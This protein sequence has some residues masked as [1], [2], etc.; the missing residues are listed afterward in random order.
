MSTP[1]RVNLYDSQTSEYHQAFQAFLDHTDQKLKAQDWLNRLVTSLP[2]RR[3]FI[4]V[5]AGNGKVTSWFI[6]SFEQTIATEPNESLRTEL[7]KNCPQIE[8]LPDRILNAKIADTGDFVLCSHVLY[9][10]DSAEWLFNLERL[11][12]WLSLDGVLV[13]VLQHHMSDCMQMLQHFFDRRFD[14]TALART[15]QAENG[16]W[17]E[18]AI[19]TVSAHVTTLNFN[20]AYT[21]AEFMLN[22]LPMSNPPTR[23]DLEEYVRKYFT[24]QDGGFRFSCDQDFLQIRPRKLPA[25]ATPLLFRDLKGPG[26]N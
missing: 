20:S 10:I 1:Q 23:S 18:V 14:L 16:D 13:V 2:S 21:V 26:S 22:S 9:H 11:A 5:G 4:D 15:F 12:S 17:Y 24:C 6:D 8:V 25:S 3:V 7:K 19:E